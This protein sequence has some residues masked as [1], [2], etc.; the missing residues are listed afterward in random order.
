[1]VAREPGESDADYELR[2]RDHRH[3]K[4]RCIG[5]SSSGAAGSAAPVEIAEEAPKTKKETRVS[6]K[7]SA[8]PKIGFYKPQQSYPGG[9]L[10]VET[11]RSATSPGGT[12]RPAVTLIGLANPADQEP[13]QTYQV[14]GLRSQSEIR[15]GS[16]PDP[17]ER[18]ELAPRPPR[19]SPALDAPW[20]CPSASDLKRTHSKGFRFSKHKRHLR[21]SSYRS[22][23]I[24][25]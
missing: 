23:A 8:K 9:H 3:S 11:A 15:Q 10:Q 22:I 17:S 2:R 21:D 19:E 13:T 18:L 7:P 12:R 1:M 24:M 16:G 6:P 5:S 4:S 14:R 20:N 25:Q